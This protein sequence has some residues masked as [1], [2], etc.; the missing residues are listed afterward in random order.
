[1]IIHARIVTQEADYYNKDAIIYVKIKENMTLREFFVLLTKTSTKLKEAKYFRF[2]Y[3]GSRLTRSEL[4]Q[5]LKT[6]KFKSGYMV[7]L[8]TGELG[9]D[10]EMFSVEDFIEQQKQPENKIQQSDKTISQQTLKST[11]TNWP[12]LRI[13]IGVIDLLLLVATIT[14]FLLFFLT[15]FISSIVIPIVLT[16]LFV[17]FTILFFGGNGL[18]PK[19]WLEKIDL[20]TGFFVKNQDRDEDKYKKKEGINLTLKREKDKIK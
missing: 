1:M 19:S 13:I 12:P 2:L 9:S 15:N 6:L 17:A 11:K 7:T 14:A 10:D 5:S 18:L 16:I 20:G 4:D 8:E 3:G